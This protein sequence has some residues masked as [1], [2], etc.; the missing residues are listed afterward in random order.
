[1]CGICGIITGTISQHEVGI[2]RRLLYL[3]AFRGEDSTGVFAVKNESGK[4]STPFYK[5]IGNPMEWMSL[6]DNEFKTELHTSDTSAL[7]GHTRH[8]TKGSVSKANAHPFDFENVI[9]VHNGT[10]WTEPTLKGKKPETDSEALY[11]YM[12]EH[13]LEKTLSEISDT[14]DAYTLVFYD[15]K[16]K[17]LN[18]IRNDKRPLSFVPVSGG[19]TIYWASEAGMLRWIL[20][21]ENI[22]YEDVYTIHPGYLLTFDMSASNP[23]LNYDLVKLKIKPKPRVYNTVNHTRHT[24]WGGEGEHRP[25]FI[26]RGV[27]RPGLVDSTGRSIGTTRPHDSSTATANSNVRDLID[28][29]TDWEAQLAAADGTLVPL[30]FDPATNKLVPKEELSKSGIV[31]GPPTT[32]VVPIK[33]GPAHMHH[34]NGGFFWIHNRAFDK[35]ELEKKLEKGCA[36]CS[37]QGEITEK[38]DWLNLEDY[39]CESCVANPEV[40]EY[41]PLYQNTSG[42]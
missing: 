33:S 17:T 30:Q 39:L 34:Q 6:Y 36:W 3:S 19:S 40:Q 8:A 12:N 5:D 27:N 38:I 11:A 42:R 16:A 1:M 41:R 14:A 35:K 18:A 31:K 20:D 37:V 32:N 26:D 29:M 22:K 25:P 2:F 9:G 23:A 4:M 13:G 24:A 15:K 10:L 28:G 21:R 7:I